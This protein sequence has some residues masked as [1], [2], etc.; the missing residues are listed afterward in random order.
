MTSE[1][2]TIAAGALTAFVGVAMGAFGAHAL[3]A[4]LDPALMEVYR[5]AVQYHLV[6]ALALVFTGNFQGVSRSS[7]TWALAAA[8]ALFTGVVLFS[9][10]LY[11]LALTGVRA[12]GAVTPVGGIAFLSGWLALAVAAL[13]R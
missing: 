9:G 3:R 2:I 13:R 6:H 8:V 11:L 5:T 4:T 7:R 10:S 12:W 1:R